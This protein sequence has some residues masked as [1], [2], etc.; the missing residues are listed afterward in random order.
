MCP[1]NID[2]QV[3]LANPIFCLP[4]GLCVGIGD[5]FELLGYAVPISQ[6]PSLP[7]GLK[8]RI[9]DSHHLACDPVVFDVRVTV[10]EAATLDP[11]L[12]RSHLNFASFF[13]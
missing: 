12:F 8:F 4:A 2:G 7:T 5:K 13:N 1:N 3:E 6:G 11:R 9:N 10:Y